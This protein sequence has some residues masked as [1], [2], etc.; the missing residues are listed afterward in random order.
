M[1]ESSPASNVESDVSRAKRLIDG[2][3]LEEALSILTGYLLTSPADTDAFDL[4]VRI[5]EEAEREDVAKKLRNLSAKIS[6][7]VSGGELPFADKAM[8]EP[9]FEAGY[10]LSDVRQ[11]ELAAKLLKTCLDIAPTEPVVKYEL[12]FALMSLKRFEEA[13]P[14]FEQ[15]ARELKD[16]DTYLNLGVCYTLTRRLDKAKDAL[17]ALSSY[18][19]ADDERKEMAHRK[20]VL[21]RIGSLGPRTALSARDWSYA[22]YGSILLDPATRKGPAPVDNYAIARMLLVLKGLLEGMRH[23]V[24]VIEY[25]STHSKPLARIMGELM[26]L[27][28]DSYKGPDRPDKALLIMSWA[29]DIIGP[30]EAFMDTSERRAIFAY[31]MPWKEPLPLVPDIIGCLADECSMPWHGANRQGSLD[32]TVQTILDRARDLECDPE[33][34]RQA[35]EAVE[36]YG[37]KKELVLLGN[38]ELFSQRPEYTAEIPAS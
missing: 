11:F 12:A 15:A 5:L 38:T 19:T 8:V 17:D 26:E 21:K 35:Q 20:T 27:P 1:P 30:H 25:Y 7:T 6:A 28:S 22:L 33:I 13:I 36:F 37:L 9:L 34:L 31:G 16:F 3:E 18:V 2:G 23:E 29:A 10:A 4:L 24:E 14:Y 32:Q